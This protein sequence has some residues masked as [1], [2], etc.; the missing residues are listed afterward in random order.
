[1]RERALNEIFSLQESIMLKRGLRWLVL[2]SA[3]P[4]L[5]SLYRGVYWLLI[6][7]ATFILRRYRSIVAIYV[8]RGCAKN[9][10][11]PGISDIDFAIFLANN[12]EEKKA[13][14]NTFQALDKMTGGVIEYYPNLVTTVASLQDRWHSAPAW[15]YRYLEG[16]TTWKLLH[17]TDVLAALP[18]LSE[19]QRR[20]SCYAEMNRWWLVFAKQMFQTGG[21]QQSI[22]MQNVTCYKAVS[23]LLNIQSVLS[24]GLCRN[25][26]AEALEDAD[27]PLAKR[28][29]DLAVHRFFSRD[30]QV[31]DE[32]FRFLVMFFIELWEGFRERPFLHVYQKGLQRVDCPESERQIGI[33]E[34]Q[35]IQALQQHLETHW[36]RKCLETHLMKSAFW[37]FDD[38][39]WIIDLDPL[40]LPTV[41]EVASLTALHDS[42]RQGPSQNIFLFLRVQSVAFPI[43][44]VMPRDLHR[45]LLTPATMP[46]VFLQ[47]GTE[48]VYWTDYTQWYLADWLAN[49]QWLDAPEQKKRQ[50]SAITKSVESGHIVYPL[51]LPALERVPWQ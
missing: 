41:R 10:I 33:K 31:G 29:A 28:L 50:L 43:T 26:R 4:P 25:S 32:A 15:Q 35:H 38:L 20:S 1:M 47:L 2:W 3:H 5:L 13:V 21:R 48:K 36:G 45:G 19:T 34:Q 30:D 18:P 22:V 46:D 23:E 42:V 16:R 40:L 27:F 11:M 39:L 37:D 12:S 8:C 44:P 51:T 49:Q 17:G 24:T 7:C 6:W 14:Q 9:Q